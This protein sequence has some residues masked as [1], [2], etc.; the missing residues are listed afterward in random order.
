MIEDKDLLN[1]LEHACVRAGEEKQKAAHLSNEAGFLREQNRLLR[2][3]NRDLERQVEAG[4]NRITV[5][6]RDLEQACRAL[7][8]LRQS[9]LA[10]QIH[11]DGCPRSQMGRRAELSATLAKDIEEAVT[12]LDGWIPF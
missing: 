10:F 8:T 9:A 12:A 4:G 2:E 1:R 3:Q 7:D 5:I 11:V 6:E